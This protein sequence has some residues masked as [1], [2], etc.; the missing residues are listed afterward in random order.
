MSKEPGGEG[1]DLDGRRRRWREHNETRRQLIIDAAIAVLE[2]QV[3]GEEVQVQLIADEAG[4]SRTVIYRHFQDRRDLDLA[5]QEEISRQIGLA[6]WPALSYDGKP[7]DIIRRVVDAFVRWAVAHP[8]LHWF[9]EID[10]PG[11]G[12][13]PL[14]VAV[15]HIAERI[16]QIMETVFSYLG[17]E[18]SAAD[19]AGLD[20]W[21][22]G[23][24]GQVFETVRRWMARPVREPSVD[25]IINLLTETIWIQADG[26]A[27]VRGIELPDAEIAELLSGLDHPTS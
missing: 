20:P 17:A 14:V 3:P 24:I 10:L 23:L 19:K 25:G 18:L 2:R 12:V 22:F 11:G 15:T 21:V 5:V 1:D 13:S 6:M 7:V 4:L 8:T 16:E 27:R 26:M 9:V